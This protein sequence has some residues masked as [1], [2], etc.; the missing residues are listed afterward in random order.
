MDRVKRLLA[1][2]DRWQRGHR[3]AAVIWAVPNLRS[4]DE[5][6]GRVSRR[7]PNALRSR[8]RGLEQQNEQAAHHPGRLDGRGRD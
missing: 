1:G 6:H 5:P 2:I 8:A 7:P 3:A 4:P